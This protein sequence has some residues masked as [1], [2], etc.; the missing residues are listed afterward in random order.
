MALTFV[1][2]CLRQRAEES[3]DARLPH[4]QLGGQIDNLGLNLRAAL[5]TAAFSC[6]ANQSRAKHLRIVRRGFFG[7]AMFPTLRHRT[8]RIVAP[9]PFD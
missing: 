7:W 8:R 5:R 6:L 4:K 1:D 9:A 2:H 3:F